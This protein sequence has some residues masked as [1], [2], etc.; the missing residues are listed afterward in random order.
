MD[1]EAKV[2]SYGKERE[3]EEG[4]KRQRGMGKRKNPALCPI[5]SDRKM[6]AAVHRV[7]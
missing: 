6:I 7:T 3:E 4:G 1:A 2:E 5:Y